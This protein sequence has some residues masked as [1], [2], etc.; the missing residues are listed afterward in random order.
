MP[1]LVLAAAAWLAGLVIAHHWLAPSGVRPASLLLL[2]LIPQAAILL[3]RRDRSMLLGAFC[4][5]A[6]LGGALRYQVA[7]PDFNDP[8]LIAYYNDG[9]WLTIEGVVQAYPDLRDTYTNLRLR[10]ESVEIGD[11]AVPVRGT[12]LVRAPRFPEHHYGDRLLV[13]GLLE[14]PPEFEGFSYRD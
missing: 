14:T 13:S 1:P 5:L 11:Q 2:A 9:G 6:L 3:W 4:A 12:V 7:Q 10:A 8:G